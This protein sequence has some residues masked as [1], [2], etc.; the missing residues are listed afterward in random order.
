MLTIPRLAIRS[1]KFQY[2]RF[3]RFTPAILANHHKRLRHVQLFDLKRPVC[4]TVPPQL[5]PDH[6]YVL[7]FR[8][9]PRPRSN[10]SFF[11]DCRSNR[12]PHTS[13]HD[14]SRSTIRLLLPDRDSVR[15]S[16]ACTHLERQYQRE[17]I[18][19]GWWCVDHTMCRPV[20]NCPRD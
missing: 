16:I 11:R 15:H 7:P 8:P 9:L 13:T 14:I 17:R 20:R 19:K 12:L 3:L 1:L 10:S 6:L 2:Q 5:H 18:E 4:A